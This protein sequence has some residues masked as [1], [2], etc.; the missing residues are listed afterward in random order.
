MIQVLRAAFR[1]GTGLRRIG[2]MDAERVDI[3][4]RWL[5]G[6]FVL[7]AMI[8]QALWLGLPAIFL[9][10]ALVLSYWLWT[11]TSWHLHHRLRA[12]FIAAIILF[13]GHAVEEFIYGFPAA[14]P[15]LFGRDPWSDARYVVFNSLWALIFAGAAVTLRPG[16]HLSILIVLFF[17]VAGGVG[18]GVAHLLLVLRLGE[19]FPGAWTAPLLLVVGIWLLRLLYASGLSDRGDRGTDHPG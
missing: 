18:N 8:F 2:R 10:A 15:A 16:R 19:Y 13:L 14:L 6:G 1:P 11:S 17:A 4:A 12:V 9:S 7:A 5:G 3:R